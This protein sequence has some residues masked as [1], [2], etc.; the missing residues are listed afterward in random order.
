[1][2]PPTTPPPS[3]PQK[4]W[5]KIAEKLQNELFLREETIALLKTRQ[6]D[7]FYIKTW[8]K[9]AERADAA[10]KELEKKEQE[11]VEMKKELEEKKQV[12][13]YLNEIKINYM[14][15]WSNAVLRCRDTEKKLK[16]KQ[17]EIHILQQTLPEQLQ[18]ERVH[19]R[20][21]MVSMSDSYERV[22]SPLLQMLALQTQEIRRL[23]ELFQKCPDDKA[24]DV[25]NAKTPGEK[26]AGD[27]LRVDLVSPNP[28]ESVIN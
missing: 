20:A 11:I 5:K 4:D 26:Q 19:S 9:A 18:Y 21:F 22:L 2:Q 8:Q 28:N 14:N 13:T 6:P 15:A 27:G 3:Y 24:T 7:C 23:Q 10:D 16:Q 1:M 12:I 17:E 25:E